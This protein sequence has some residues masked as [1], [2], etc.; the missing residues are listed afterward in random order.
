MDISRFE[1]Y[2]REEYGMGQYS[3]FVRQLNFYGF[4]KVRNLKKNILYRHRM[5]KKDNE[6]NISRISRKKKIQKR[7]TQNDKLLKMKMK[8]YKRVAESIIDLEAR[9]NKLE[10]DNKEVEKAN[11]I[12]SQQLGDFNVEWKRRLD[13]KIL[14]FCLFGYY[15]NLRL[16]KRVCKFFIDS[17]FC[18]NKSCDENQ[19]KENFEP[20]YEE[21]MMFAKI[22]VKKLLFYT[23]DSENYLDKFYDVVIDGDKSKV[24]KEDFQTYLQ[25]YTKEFYRVI[26]TIKSAGS[27]NDLSLKEN[28]DKEFSEID[29]NLDMFNGRKESLLEIDDINDINFGSRSIKLIGF[30][31]N[32]SMISFSG[33]IDQ[34]EY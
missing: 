14:C 30:S 3:S 21:M 17:G 28:S 27:T 31:D 6:I 19:K 32:E 2:I 26:R 25:V 18:G 13:K 16:V 11:Q 1:T 9:I 12:I 15:W 20:D 4:S 5:F 8:E 22:R 34:F 33:L 23:A 10:N 7:E 24:E 29:Y